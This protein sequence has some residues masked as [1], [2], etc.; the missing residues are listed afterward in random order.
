MHWN[1]GYVS[2]ID[3]TYGYYKEL[4]PQN[5]RLALSLNGVKV[6][7]INTACE[8][9]I[10][11]G[12]TLNFS[13]INDK[14]E[15]YGNDFNP[16]QLLFAKSLSEA[17]S[18]N[19]HLFD[20]E[21]ETFCQ[22]TDLPNFDFICLHGIWSWISDRNRSIIK[23]FIKEKLNIGGVVYISYNTS[24]GWS[25][26]VPI[27]DLMYEFYNQAAANATIPQERI[28]FAITKTIELLEQ[29]SLYSKVF[30]SGLKRLEKLLGSN[31]EYLA[32]EYFNR[33]WKPISFSNM[34]REL[35]EA[36][37]QYISSADLLDLVPAANFSAEQIHYLSGIPDLI[38]QQ[39]AKDFLENRQFRKEYWVK[40]MQ[41]LSHT[42]QLNQLSDIAVVRV[43][44]VDFPYSV[45]RNGRKISFSEAIYKPILDMLSDFKP[46]Q[47]GLIARQLEEKGINLQ[48]LK[49]AVSVL[50]GAGILSAAQ[51]I[52]INDKIIQNARSLNQKIIQ[53]SFTGS[54]LSHLVSPLTTNG[55]SLNFLQKVFCLAIFN[56]ISAPEKIVEFSAEQLKLLS[57]RVLRD[58]KSIEDDGEHD[59]EL[60]RL[61]DDFMQN[62][63]PKLKSLHIV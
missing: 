4:Q 27:R 60:R 14:V 21:F 38:Q 41:K 19:T 57:K 10:G 63:Y 26:M 28:E 46:R 61:V 1:L 40:G 24:P 43:T 47:L 7:E 39:A 36:K 9:G 51:P 42:E 6:P 53:S 30:P 34:N 13:A 56:G 16:N 62:T 17:A 12:V 18:T 29:D 58:G 20:D 25:G 33:D 48:V 32:H 37:L 5:V 3:Y 55:I 50:Y 31:K 22:R 45:E 8:L 49:E 11:Q 54:D 52:E 35:T 2:E 44:E 59:A 23:R 15:W